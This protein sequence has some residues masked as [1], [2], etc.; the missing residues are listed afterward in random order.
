MAGTFDPYY[1][2][3]DNKV[4]GDYACMIEEVRGTRVLAPR[5]GRRPSAAYRHGTVANTPLYFGEKT[6]TLAISVFDTD[7][8]H[9]QNHPAGPIGHLQHNTDDL[10]AIFGKRGLIDFRQLMPTEGGGTVELQGYCEVRRQVEVENFG[11]A[12]R[13]I[14]ELVFPYPFL[15]ELPK[16][17]RPAA[18]SHSFTTGGTAPIAD[19]VFTF[20]GAGKVTWG[21]W[22][23][24]VK[25]AAT[26]DVGK[27]EVYVSNQLKMSALDTSLN[28]MENWMEWLAKTAISLSSTV[29]VGV[30]YYNARH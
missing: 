3:V 5:R 23:L 11:G 27:R 28:M 29:A 2:K 8:S 26:V 22:E 24:G 6:L 17:T 25:E 15:H 13:M 1:I 16:I 30:E 9:E 18:T 12:W 7:D 14:V 4:L 19:M 20:S 10:W 21:S